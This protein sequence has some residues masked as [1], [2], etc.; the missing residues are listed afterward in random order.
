[1]KTLSIQQPFPFL[2][3]RPDLIDSKKR[4]AAIK[5][6]EI[7]LIENRTW[8]TT[9]RG[10]FL[11]HSSARPARDIDTYRDILAEF[12]IVIPATADL[13]YG[14]IVGKAKL[15]NVVSEAE[16]FW[17][18]GPFGFVLDNPVSFEIPQKAKG[19]LGF[20]DYIFP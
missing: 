12:G 10:D 14:Q 15:I 20:W 11:I 8:N 13:P 16:D 19:K 7:K 3:L 4:A 18:T 9:H 5:N 17:F 1:M 6:S 2:I